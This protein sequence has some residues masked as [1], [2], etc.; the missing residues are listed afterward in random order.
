[1][2]LKKPASLR[3]TLAAATCSLLAGT[4]AN[5]QAEGPGTA[6][7]WEFDSALLL[8]SEKDRVQ[9]AEPVVRLKKQLN[10]DESI[11][12]RL[13]VDALTGSS[14]NGAVPSS[15]P[16]TFTSPSGESAYTTPANQ[17]PLDPNFRDTRA[18]LSVDWARPAGANRRVVYQGHASIESDYASLGAGATLSQDFNNRNTTLTG[19][20]SY[21]ADLIKPEG[22]IPNG[23]TAM[24][25]YPALKTPA[26]GE[27][28]K[29]VL[30]ALLGV[31]QVLGRTSLLQINYTFGRDSGYLTDP[32]KLV[33]VVD[34]AGVP[35]QT[36]FE[37][38]PDER[39]RQSL[40]ARSQT[41]FDKDVLNASYRYY[42]DD[43]GVRAH[44]ADVRYRF[45]L[46]GSYLEPHL[47]YSIQSKA[48]D[49]YR[50]Y[51][52]QGETVSNVSADY[53]LSEMTTSTLGVKY[54]IPG[55]GGEFTIRLEVMQQR[56]DDHPAGAPG[57]LAGQDLFPDT[58]A[59]IFQIGYSY[60][61]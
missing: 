42:W 58:Q 43:W 2:Q 37:K 48:A 28:N 10:E 3:R 50:P 35:V 60:R 36:L 61:W 29:D 17:I 24:P 54:G 53:R 11:S 27:E 31:T 44:T 13:V 38:R 14:P 39:F 34:N 9:A 30:D 1:M 32:Y 21:N 6:G 20:L 33:S 46:G 16:Q 25:A 59:T 47:R 23:L 19:G 4:H 51:L 18:A 56:G 7:A 26:S 8:Y 52:L 41:A 15:A 5:A 45:D 55:K 49:F 22:G 12:A 40:Y 57:Q